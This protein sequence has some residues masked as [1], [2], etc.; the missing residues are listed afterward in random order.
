VIAK[1]SRQLSREIFHYALRILKSSP[2]VLHS[3]SFDI[4]ELAPSTR[5]NEP[6]EPNDADVLV[7]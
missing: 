3:D 2:A 6:M 1:T 4:H 5:N 7:D